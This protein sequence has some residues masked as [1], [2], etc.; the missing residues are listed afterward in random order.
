MIVLLQLCEDDECV[1]I[2][3]AIINQRT[4]IRRLT[5]CRRTMHI[6]EDVGLPRVDHLHTVVYTPGLLQSGMGV[7]AAVS[8]L[9]SGLVVLSSLPEKH[10]DQRLLK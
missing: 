4:C 6:T 8:A 3:A 1:V 5:I 9:P 7:T 2:A 10:L